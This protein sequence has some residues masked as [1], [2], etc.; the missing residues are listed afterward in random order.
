MLS[1]SLLSIVQRC[2]EQKLLND[3]KKQYGVAPEGVS[4]KCFCIVLILPTRCELFQR[5]MADDGVDCSCTD[6]LWRSRSPAPTNR[7]ST[8]RRIAYR[9]ASD[10]RSPGCGYAGSHGS[11]AGARGASGQKRGL[12]RTQGAVRLP[13]GPREGPHRG[14]VAAVLA[15]RPV[16]FKPDGS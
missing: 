13:W 14:Q 10:D 11:S 1:A 12:A 16:A 6:R 5:V 9:Q 15:P 2:G 8:S 3:I 7:R 4:K